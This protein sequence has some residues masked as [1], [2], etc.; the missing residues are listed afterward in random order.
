MKNFSVFLSRSGLRVVIACV[1][2]SIPI[3]YFAPSFASLLYI[4]LMSLSPFFISFG[5]LNKYGLLS[6][7]VSHTVPHDVTA[8]RIVV[9][10]EW[11]E[12]LRAGDRRVADHLRQRQMDGLK[13]FFF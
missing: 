10:V 11:D 2:Y 4:L 12:V 13:V 6:F 9:L 7:D 8:R 1:V 5:L 3:L